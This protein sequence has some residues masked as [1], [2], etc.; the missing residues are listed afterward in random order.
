MT[1]HFICFYTHFLF[2]VFLPGDYDK[3]HKIMK[4]LNMTKPIIGISMDSSKENTYS[5]YPWYAL[6]EH[7]CDTVH[8]TGGV[9]VMLPHTIE[10]IDHYLDL[11]DGVAISGGDFDHDPKFYGQDFCHEKTVLNSPRSAFD[12]AFVKKSLERDTPLLGIC[13]GQQMLNIVRG[14]TLIQHIPDTHPDALQHS[15]A[16]CRHLPTHDITITKGTLLAQCSKGATKVAVNTSHHQAIDKI[17][18]DLIINAVASDGIIEGIE[19]PNLT[20]CLGVQW[21]PE[22]L[23]GDLDRS[24]YERFIEAAAEARYK[25][26]SSKLRA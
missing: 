2:A 19:D 21:H 9:P 12:F 3:R 18:K 5:Q 26:K 25:K 6:R 24:L 17:G 20:F 10:L 7:Y 11:V 23:V 15:Q 13:A 22:F 8:K 1:R 4:D 16:Q 14:G